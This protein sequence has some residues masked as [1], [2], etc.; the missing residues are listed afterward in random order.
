[1]KFIV[2]SDIHFDHSRMNYQNLHVPDSE[3]TTLILAGDINSG[4]FDLLETLSMYCDDFKRVI[5]VAG[6]HEFYHSS[7]NQIKAALRDLARIRSNFIFLDNQI[8]EVEGITIGGSTLWG[9][10]TGIEDRLNDLRL[11][12]EFKEDRSLFGILHLEDMR[13]VRENMSKVDIMVTH[14]CPHPNLSNPMFGRN[15]L[16]KYF[17]PEIYDE[18]LDEVPDIWIFGHTHYSVDTKVGHTRFIS[19]QWGYPEEYLNKEI[20]VYEYSNGIKRKVCYRNL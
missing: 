10:A 16:T 15:V 3:N 5:F 2:V 12:Q 20:T 1:M 17:C 7:L 8:V 4:E 11:V 13:W 14:F 18:Q 19:N 6:N 9:D